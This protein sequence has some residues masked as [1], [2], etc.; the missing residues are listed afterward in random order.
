MLYYYDYFSKKKVI[1]YGYEVL[2][3]KTVGFEK[4]S[5]ESFKKGDL[6]LFNKLF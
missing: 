5:F 2:E 4:L 1:L 3:L 6:K